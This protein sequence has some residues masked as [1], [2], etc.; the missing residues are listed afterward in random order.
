VTTTGHTILQP[1]PESL[2][3][4]GSF[5][6]ESLDR[7][8]LGWLSLVHVEERCRLHRGHN[9]SA[10]SAAS[11]EVCDKLYIS[12][13]RDPGRRGNFSVWY[14]TSDGIAAIETQILYG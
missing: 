6:V 12:R 9:S 7:E 1:S 4:G 11:S 2:R 8:A 10:V 5:L 13:E 14:N 3:S